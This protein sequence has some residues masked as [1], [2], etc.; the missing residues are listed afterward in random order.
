MVENPPTSAGNIRDA[1]SI[2]GSGRSPRGGNGNP[3]QYS[4][5]E[6]SHGQR[7]QAGYSPWGCKESDMTK[8]LSKT[9]NSQ[10]LHPAMPSLAQA[11]KDHNTDANIIMLENWKESKVHPPR[12][13]SN[14]PK[15][16]TPEQFKGMRDSQ[17]HMAK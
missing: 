10:T 15:L 1:G 5:L 14:A 11:G 2:P 8:Q 6:K 13:V 7:S 16:N 17:N 9:E 4:C 3:L 12:K